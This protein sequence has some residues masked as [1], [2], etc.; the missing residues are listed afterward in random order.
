MKIL[1]FASLIG[2]AIGAFACGG[3]SSGPSGPRAASVTGIA[4]DSQIAPTNVPLDFPLSMTLLG[5]NGQPI[6]GVSVTWS[7]VPS[8]GALFTPQVSV[9]DANGIV[10]TTV[11]MGAIQDTIVISATVPGVAQPVVFHALAVDPCTFARSY[12]VGATANGV[13]TT[14]DCQAG[15][16][17]YTD[18]YIFSVGAQTGVTATMAASTFDA[19][20]DAY[21]G[22]GKTLAVNNNIDNT[23]T[24]AQVELILAAGTY[25]L[26]PNTYFQNATGAYTLSST[27]RAQ[28]LSGCAEAWVSAG[29]TIT[30]NLATTDC[31][32]SVGSGVYYD[33]VGIIAFP[34]DTLRFT[35]RS[36]AFNPML[37]LYRIDPAGFTQV[38][39]NDDS[40]ATTTAF[41]NYPVTATAG[42][43]YVLYLGSPD[44]AATGAYTMIVDGSASVKQSPLLAP[45]WMRAG[46]NQ[47]FA[48]RSLPKTLTWH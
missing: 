19:W 45:G 12:T 9:S 15:G 35:G 25:I 26:A 5:S 47:R 1:A 23:T 42:A 21:R 32:D 22:N 13:L 41:I 44:T 2:G 3:D 8:G 11:T 4:G 33:Q 39:F 38:A 28:T 37:T 18:F 48:E 17:F 40:A 46:A 16:P 14:Y 30:D 7:V 10:S 24:N 43:V 27:V 31:I 36:T 20:L 34:G 6:Q 29:I